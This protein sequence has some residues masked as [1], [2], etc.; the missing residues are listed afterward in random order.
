MA[1]AA[2]AEGTSLVR[3]TWQT[4]RH[5]AQQRQVSLLEHIRSSPDTT[6]KAAL[7]EDSVAILGLLLAFAGLLL[8]QLT[9]SEVYDAAGNC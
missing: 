1:V 2:I 6:V 8:R 4:T 3:A 5:Q 9:G 7:F